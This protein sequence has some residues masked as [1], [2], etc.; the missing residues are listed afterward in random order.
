MLEPAEP[1]AVDRSAGAPV[2][3]SSRETLHAQAERHVP[4]HVAVREERMVLEHQAEPAP[5]RGDVCEVDTV[6][7]KAP[8]RIGGEAGNRAEQRAL[9]R[10]ARPEDAHD[11]VVRDRQVDVLERGE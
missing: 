3:L 5:V 11:L 9:P 1:D 2:D 8:V 4:Q 6:P 7:R 10:P